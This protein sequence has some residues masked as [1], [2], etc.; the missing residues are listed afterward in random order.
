M[1]F[2]QWDSIYDVR[3][4]HGGPLCNVFNMKLLSTLPYKAGQDD[5]PEQCYW[6]S[7]F[8]LLTS[9]YANLAEQRGG[10]GRIKTQ[11]ELAISELK[12]D[13]FKSILF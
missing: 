5:I 8:P 3:K 2:S 13:H 4:D 7:V 9:C 1:N 6:Y 12:C 11:S 10:L